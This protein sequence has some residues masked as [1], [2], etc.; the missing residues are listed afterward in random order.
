MRFASACLLVI[1][2]WAIAQG[3]A[4]A[5][6]AAGLAGALALRGFTL[7][8][9]GDG[10]SPLALLIDFL[11]L[12]A[13]GLAVAP[14]ALLWGA[15]H[16]FSDL[17]RLTPAGGIVAALLYLSAAVIGL[18]KHGKRTGT[19]ACA[20]LFVLPFLFNL[21]LALG[22]PL[23]DRVAGMLAGGAA[24]PLARVLLRGVDPVRRQ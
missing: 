14:D 17:L 3:G 2:V 10:G 5:A 23:L 19:S 13:L 1:A 9:T 7:T 20:A 6:L 21:L 12:A 4:V 11:A 24:L 16:H 22:S 8:M 18:L 15:P